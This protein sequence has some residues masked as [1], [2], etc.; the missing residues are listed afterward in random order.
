[1]QYLAKNQIMH[2][3][4]AARNV[5]ID[6]DPLKSGYPLAKV[7]DFGLSKKFYD[8]LKYKKKARE[9]VPWKWMA[10]EYLTSDYFTLTSD[11]WSF[12]VVVWEILSFGRN[13]YGPQDYNEV[14]EQLENG[15]RLPC[16]R[17]ID[18]ISTWSP[19]GLYNK[20]SAICFVS[21]PLERAHF[22][23]VVKLIEKELSQEEIMRY[24]QM[25]EKYQTSCANQYLQQSGNTHI[26]NT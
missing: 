19:E 25:S 7:A 6:E 13:P 9:F 15:Y 10:L 8:N 2:G 1:M 24:T 16:P 14:L 23:K 12:A 26:S 22:S 11:V 4:L 5:L 18:E 21:D 3:D 20:I 17:D